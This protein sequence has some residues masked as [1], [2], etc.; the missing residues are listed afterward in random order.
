MG[1]LPYILI[2]LFLILN[3]LSFVGLRTECSNYNENTLYVI[4]ES[5][6]MPVWGI[7]ILLLCIPSIIFSFVVDFLCWKPFDRK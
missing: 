7:L 4:K 5:S 1:D 6:D 3:F 2:A